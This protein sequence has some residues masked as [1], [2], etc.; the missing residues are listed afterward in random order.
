MIALSMGLGAVSASEP[1]GLL[2]AAAVAMFDVNWRQSWQQAPVS[3][4]R[5]PDDSK[6]VAAGISGCVSQV[7]PTE[8][9]SP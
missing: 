9:C 3:G 7:L 4:A 2:R 6:V 8:K 5:D 1:N